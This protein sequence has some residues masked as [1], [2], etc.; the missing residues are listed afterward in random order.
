MSLLQRA[1]RA[2][3]AAKLWSA[4]SGECLRADG[5]HE[6]CVPSAAFAPDGQQVL[7]ASMDEAAKLWPAASKGAC[8]LSR[9]AK[10]VTSAAFAPDGQ[11][12]LTA[13]M[14]GIAKL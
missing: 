4:A 8:A 12:V 2:D 7:T 3:E 11:Q 9:A 13:S 14:D 5:G 1:L 10:I 6:D